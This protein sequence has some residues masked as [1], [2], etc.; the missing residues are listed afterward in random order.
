MLMFF[1][2]THLLAVG[3]RDSGCNVLLLKSECLFCALS[4]QISVYVQHNN[5]NIICTYKYDDHYQPNA[6]HNTNSN[7]IITPILSTSQHNS[8][9][10]I[11]NYT[12]IIF[13]II[14]HPGSSCSSSS[15][16]AA[17]LAAARDW[18]SLVSR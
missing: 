18:A 1:T 5:C 16:L 4:F 9:K 15:L 17:F 11:W 12:I 2:H 7:I 10:L 14:P 3:H 13:N 8:T 6:H